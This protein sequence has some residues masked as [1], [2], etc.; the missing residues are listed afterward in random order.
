MKNSVRT[1]QTI[2]PLVIEGSGVDKIR[3][4]KNVESES[5]VILGSRSAVGLE[6]TKRRAED[7]PITAVEHG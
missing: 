2:N 6:D 1:A 7:N 3:Q 5:V 4:T